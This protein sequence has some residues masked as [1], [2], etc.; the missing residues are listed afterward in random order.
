MMLV[1][2]AV[3]YARR[4]WRVIPLHAVQDGCCTCRDSTCES[5]GKHPRL[6]A[7]PSQATTVGP[8]IIGWWRTWPTANIG[9]VTGADSDLVVLDVDGEIGADS[10]RNL[11]RHHG[12]LPESVISLTGR[13]GQHILFR[14][15]GE[16]ISNAVK[17]WPG[18]DVRGDGGYIVAPPSRTVGLYAWQLGNEPGTVPLAPIPAWLLDHLHEHRDAGDRLCQHGTPLVLREG[19]RNVGL[20]RLACLLRRRG[21][22]ARALHGCLEAINLEH[23]H[24]P[25][26][27]AELERIAA[28]AARYA[29]ASRAGAAA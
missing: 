3:A 29:P 1:D 5:R 17:L 19:E 23:A 16:P 7:W 8:T 14:H 18:I 13:G 4:R 22:N 10:L 12:A 15:P 26:G 6:T 20:F 25:L 21:V 28:S 2:C 11:E 24:P 27:A 9:I